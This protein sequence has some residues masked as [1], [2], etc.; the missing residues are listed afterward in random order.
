M[1]TLTE[2]LSDISKE[3]GETTT[4]VVARRIQ[5]GNDAV[6][7]FANERKWPFLVKENTSMTTI[8]G[9]QDYA[10]H[11][12]ILADWRAPGAIKEITIGDNKDPITEIE[13]GQ[14]GDSRWDGAS[15]F[16]VD[17]EGTTIYFKTSIAKTGDIIHVH[18]FYIPARVPDTTS[19]VTFPIP[20]RYR[21]ALGLLGAAYVQF[22]RYLET[23]GNR[24]FNM[25]VKQVQSITTQQSERNSNSPRRIQHYLQAIGFRRRYP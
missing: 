19:V 24:L 4:N 14:R 17:P 13:W 8:S 7:D 23:Q 22:S 9:D 12:N 18:Y 20:S 25:Y 21:K 2:L 5:H 3:L 16:Y 1:I 6:I 15:V 10:I 11:A